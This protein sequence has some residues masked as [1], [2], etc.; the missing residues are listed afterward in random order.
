[1][2]Y[3]K[4][5]VILCHLGV[6]IA[7]S[8][9][10]VEWVSRDLLAQR[11]LIDLDLLPSLL[12]MILIWSDGSRRPLHHTPTAKRFSTNSNGVDGI[13]KTPPNVMTH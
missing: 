3:I 8:D 1:M 10:A 9:T 7:A 5:S 6:A 4:W 2:N 11:L 13:L 12:G